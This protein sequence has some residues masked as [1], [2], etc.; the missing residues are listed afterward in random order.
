MSNAPY[1]HRDVLDSLLNPKSSEEIKNSILYHLL[2]VQGRDPERAGPGD[3]YKAL[4]L[5]MRDSL[6]EKWIKTQR[7]YYAGRKKRV[8]YLSLEFLIG[9]SLANAM[10]NLDCRD[11]VATALH[12]LG[13]DLE[14]ILDKEEDAALGNGGLGRLAACFM[15]SIATM[16][17]P[18]YGYGIN[19]E[20]GLF[21]QK[22]INGHQVES[23]DNWLRFGNVWEFERPMPLYPV[24]F[25][26]RVTTRLDERG[27]LRCEWVDTEVVMAVACDVLVPG[28][29]NN[30]VIN[31]R[32]WTAKASRELDLSY[33][34]RGDYVGAVHT[35][36]HSETISKVLY[37]QDKVH[38]GQELR[39][40]QQY[41]FVA[42][43][44]QDIFRRYT[45][46]NEDFSQF[47][48][49]VAIQLN[50]THPA[51]AI[52]ELMRLLL[53]EHGL[54]WEEA[55]DI[56]VKTFAYTN[57]T[58]MPEALE[59]WTVDLLG[60][61]LPRHLEIIF[62]IN[63]RF[64]DEVRARFPRDEHKV[65]IMSIIDDGPP[66]RVRMAYLAIVGSHSV[67]GVAALHTS[68]LRN[69]M[70]KDFHEMYPDRI[71]N[72]TNGITPRRWLLLCNP[73]LSRVISERIGADW[74][75]DLD[76]LQELRPLA[77]NPG[78]QEEFRA[79]K[80]ANKLRLAQLIKELVDVTVDPESLFD[81]QVKR[82]HE[83][84][85]QLLNL[86]HVIDLY[87]RIVAGQGADIQP[88]TVI[89]AGKAAPGYWKAK[90]II[91]L[92]NAVA[93]TI[94]NDQRVGRRLKVVFL[95]NYGVSLAEKIIPAADLSEQISTAGT[96]ASGT[97]NMKF[98]L[99]G[100]LTIGTL[101][102]ANI[103][104]REEVG[105]ENIFIFGLTAQQAEYERKMPSRTP[106]M[107]YEQN[108]GIRRII[109]SLR[110]DRF[111]PDEPGL[112]APIV[113][114]LMDHH[115]D[116]YLHLLDLENYLR[117]Q[118][119]VN[120]TYRQPGEWHRKAILNVAGMGRFS[121]DRAIREYA[122]KIW[123]V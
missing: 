7:D 110:D 103:E 6:V 61:V 93:A 18:A 56:C 47:S 4:A 74:P 28:F 21:Y 114:D 63:R 33:F 95:P 40:K 15:D 96:E 34:D 102:G 115:R 5:T 123:G 23:P 70:F 118:E 45:M 86:L 9:R 72:K 73:D 49:Q 26:G 101:D 60:R 51:V 24:N 82:I 109:D 41:F 119:E 111:C 13:Y 50:D 36:V 78:L 29:H 14:E 97:G 62:E 59:T 88:R 52:P 117:C 32:L 77:G 92:I 39:L 85:R 8:Y 81:V 68:L 43:T 30:N 67:N 42:A 55:W 107:I 27:R 17:I 1:S 65:R 22:I 12:E 25:Y 64:L 69:R 58:L 89:F 57:H 19:Y 94:N 20:Y 121:S 84:K 122:T 2:S 48:N 11:K 91:K 76:R 116:P 100:A 113:D 10:L 106:W 71:N 83:Y 99:N 44:F 104:I 31:M 54:G 112:F 38:A 66:K 79:A 75:T 53:D 46:H 37:P 3:M 120:A 87:H 105:E 90:L 16:K 80:K 108:P 98:A 35:K